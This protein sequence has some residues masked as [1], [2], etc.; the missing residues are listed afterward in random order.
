MTQRIL[1]VFVVAGLAVFGARA[2]AQATPTPTETQA[3]ANRKAMTQPAKQNKATQNGAPNAAKNAQ[4]VGDAEI[5]ARAIA[6]KDAPSNPVRDAISKAIQQAFDEIPRKNPPPAAGSNAAGAKAIAAQ[7]VEESIPKPG[8][9][10]NPA[11]TANSAATGTANVAQDVTQN[12][13]TAAAGTMPNAAGNVNPRERA[14]NPTK[15]PRANAV[16]PEFQP[17]ITALHS[18]QSSLLTAGL[19]WGGHKQK[20]SNFINQALKACGQPIIPLKEADAPAAEQSADMQA[21]STQLTNAISVFTG[22]TDTWG[23]CRDQA[24]SLMNQALTEIQAG[25]DFAKNAGTF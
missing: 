16:P 1:K 11:G 25:I 6:A 12:A 18:A 9:Q 5:V 20:A 3:Q 24:V 4:P 14:A 23:G 10:V 7:N 15:T 21:G 8:S 19:K 17:A 22:A 2:Q 13:T